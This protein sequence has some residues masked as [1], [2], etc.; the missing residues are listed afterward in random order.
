VI[1]SY[2]Q[3]NTKLCH[4]RYS[5]SAK[6]FKK[7]RLLNFFFEF[8]YEVEHLK[9][10]MPDDKKAHDFI[11]SLNKL[12]NQVRKLLERDK[13]RLLMTADKFKKDSTAITL[14]NTTCMLRR[15]RDTKCLFD[16]RKKVLAE[17]ISCYGSHDRLRSSLQI[18]TNTFYNLFYA[19]N[20]LAQPAYELAE[21]LNP[22]LAPEE[23]R[24]CDSAKIFI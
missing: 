12:E 1:D 21:N 19:P 23:T 5:D 9:L 8:E 2:Y 10:Q 11:R 18:I 20:L 13:E 6:T 3:E 22:F 24:H 15:F 7:E 16:N 14:Y 4:L 17:Y